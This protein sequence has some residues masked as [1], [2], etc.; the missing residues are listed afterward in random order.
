MSN[1]NKNV[2]NLN[3]LSGNSYIFT[4]DKYPNVTFTV[5]SVNL[6]GVS[7]SPKDISTPVGTYFEAG[8]HL[9]YLPLNVSF[10][11]DESLN[12]WR[13]VYNWMRELSP[14]HVGLGYDKVSQYVKLKQE[15]LTTT[16]RLICLTNNLNI[17]VKSVF[18]DVFPVSLSGINFNVTN[19]DNE[20]IT[21]TV[22]FV[23]TYYDLTVNDDYNEKFVEN[24][25]IQ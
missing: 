12:N 24:N 7:S 13:E 10:I 1:S 9:N 2:Y 17:N 3:N 8:D 21:A 11:V 16:A 23:Y 14:T 4:L 22:S 6:P 19:E 15:G 18:Y 5:Q 25:V 20:I